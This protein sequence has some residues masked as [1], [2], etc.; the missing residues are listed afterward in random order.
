MYAFRVLSE[1][2]YTTAQFAMY[3]VYTRIRIMYGSVLNKPTCRW[4]SAGDGA[5]A[6]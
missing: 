4:W 3:S 2:A 6:G 5:I 1:N